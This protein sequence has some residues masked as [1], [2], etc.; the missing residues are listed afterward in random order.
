MTSDELTEWQVYAALEPFGAVRDDERFGRL[1]KIWVDL[2]VG[3]K[4]EKYRYEHF[5]AN[6]T[7]VDKLQREEAAVKLAMTPEMIAVN[8]KSLLSA[9]AA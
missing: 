2:K 6:Y 1:A 4:G 9:M 8:L 3:E 7:F 5:I